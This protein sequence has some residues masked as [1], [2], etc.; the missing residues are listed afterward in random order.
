MFDLSA[1]LATTCQLGSAKDLTRP[2]HFPTVLSYIFQGKIAE[3]LS[4][5]FNKEMETASIWFPKDYLAN[6]ENRK[7][8]FRRFRRWRRWL[9]RYYWVRSTSFYFHHS[10]KYSAFS[11]KIS[12][13]IRGDRRRKKDIEP[14]HWRP[15]YWSWIYFT[16]LEPKKWCIS[17]IRAS[18]T[19]WPGFRKR[20]GDESENNS[21]LWTLRFS[22]IIWCCSQ[23]SEVSYL[24]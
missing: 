4:R 24:E 1:N 11:F 5:C 16:S 23:P 14:D 21:A 2:V 17:S 9:R 13:K 15:I 10:W 8:W 19:L 18:G 20:F 22:N 3:N 12:F 6:K 7:R